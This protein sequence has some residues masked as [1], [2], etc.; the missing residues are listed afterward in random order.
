MSEPQHGSEPGGYAYYRGT[1]ADQE[2]SHRQEA[3]ELSRDLLIPNLRN[4]NYLALRERRR[5]FSQFIQG[6]QKWDLKVLDVG[7][8]LQPFRPLI[9]PYL[10]LYVAIDP[11]F[12]GLLSV[13]AIG[14]SLPFPAGAFDLVICTQMLPYV[15]DPRRVLSEIHR[16]LRNAGSLFLSVPAIFPRYHDIR[17]SFMP[18]GVR[19]L[20]PSFSEVQI[21]PEGGS[22]AG[23]MRSLNLF[24]DTFVR[25]ERAKRLVS[26]TVFPTMNLAGLLLDRFSRRRTEFTTNYTYIARK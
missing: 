2:V 19:E 17:W 9:A 13:L 22:I 15:S 12:E 3:E 8:R 4:P 14:E 16:V 5:L 26:H 7:G 11:V 18:D 1:N 20:L 23:L 6:L 10:G 25:S 24:F 21:I